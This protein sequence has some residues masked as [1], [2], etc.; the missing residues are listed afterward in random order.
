MGKASTPLLKR[1]RNISLFARYLS[2]IAG[3]I[4]SGKPPFQEKSAL[5]KTAITNKAD[6][7]FKAKA[8]MEKWSEFES[9]A[10]SYSNTTPLLMNNS[11]KKSRKAEIVA[12]NDKIHITILLSTIYSDFVSSLPDGVTRHHADQNVTRADDKM[13]KLEAR[14]SKRNFHFANLCR[15]TCYKKW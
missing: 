3:E 10:T 6:K 2:V 5:K 4:D 8:E 7:K 12:N 9:L 1:R 14:K 15:E 13:K 11:N